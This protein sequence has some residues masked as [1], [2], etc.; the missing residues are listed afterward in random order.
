MNNNNNRRMNR[1]DLKL[2]KLVLVEVL[3]YILCTFIHPIVLIYTSIS[4]GIVLNKSQARKQI[5]AFITFIA[6]SL[7]FYLNFNT[8]FYVHFFIFKSFRIEVKQLLMKLKRQLR[9]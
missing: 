3:V 1:K 8:T 2:M 4:N 9:T 6:L 5:E 7:L